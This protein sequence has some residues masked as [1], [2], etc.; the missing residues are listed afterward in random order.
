MKLWYVSTTLL[1]FLRE[2]VVANLQ[3]AR[4]ILLPNRRLRPA[5]IKVPLK[6]RSDWGIF[7]LSN[8]ITLTPGT[9]TVEVKADKSALIVHVLDCPDADLARR[10]IK[11]GFESRLLRIFS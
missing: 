2:L 1:F 10:S 7:C 5:L 6:L 9:L 11:Q 3:V 4:L 8:M